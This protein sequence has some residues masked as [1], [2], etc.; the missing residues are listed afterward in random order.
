MLD[1]VLIGKKIQSYRKSQ[2][3]S[4]EELAENLLVTRQAVS[5]WE[6]GLALPSIDNLV[7][8]TK[9][10]Q[11]SFEDLLCLDEKIEADP[12]DIFKGHT[13]GYVIDEICRGNIDVNLAEVFY[14]FSSKERMQVLM[15]LS[16]NHQKISH[17]LYVRLTDAEKKYVEREG[18]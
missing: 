6:M 15:H 13:R 8:L 14:Q 11:V 3:L 16:E 12:E 5:R 7:E 4:Q 9:I 10:L 1:L 2:R 17:D 18:L